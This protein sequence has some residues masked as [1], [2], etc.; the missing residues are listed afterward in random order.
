MVNRSDASAL[1]FAPSYSP[2]FEPVLKKIVKIVTLQ[3][4]VKKKANNG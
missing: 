3:S 2:I 1:L 4:V